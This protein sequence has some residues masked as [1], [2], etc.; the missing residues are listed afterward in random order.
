MEKHIFLPP[1]NCRD[2]VNLHLHAALEAVAQRDS[3]NR[4]DM[5]KD[6]FDSFLKEPEI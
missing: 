3:A 6:E 2:M 4:A 1:P 5:E